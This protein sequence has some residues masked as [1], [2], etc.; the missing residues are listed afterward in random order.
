MSKFTHLPKISV[1]TPVYNAIH[2]IE[3]SIKS[4][5]SQ[6]YPA[7]EY[8]II[9]GGSSDGTVDIIKK[10]EKHITYFESK[11]DRGQTHALNK[12]FFH[13]TGI[14]RG[15][16]NADEE[17]QPGALRLVGESFAES[18]ETELIFGNRYYLNLTKTPPLKVLEKIPPIAP[19]KL[20]LYTGRILASDATF[21]TMN[22]HSRVGTLDEKKYPR[23]AMDVEWFLRLT[24]IV[25][26]WKY[27]DTP[28]GTFKEHG[29]NITSE[30]VR[31]EFRYNEKIRHDYA[32]SKGISFLHFFLGW[33]WYSTKLRIWEKG[34]SGAFKPPRWDTIAHLFFYSRKKLYKK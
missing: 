33:L 24:G 13:A 5:I 8:I 34:F 22:V 12:G 2:F 26:K 32:K 15:W 3:D 19:F 30:G 7:L 27:I 10:Y 17:Y 25:K 9:D 6:D 29:S 23:Y 1:I 28:L 21:W 31:A 16:L 11:P 20:I 18:E 14:L 4:V